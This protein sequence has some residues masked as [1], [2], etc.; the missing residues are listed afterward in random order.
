MTPMTR[1]DT[2]LVVDDSPDTIRLLTDVLDSAGMTVMVA[3]D[4]MAALKVATRLKPDIVLMDAVMPG[5]DGFETCRQLKTLSGFDDVPVIFMTGLTEPEDSVRGFEAG[6]ADYVTKPIVLDSMLAR[7]RVHLSNARK[8]RSAR[9]A[10]DAAEQFLVAVDRDGE[11]TW[12]TPQAYRLLER[13]FGDETSRR[14]RLPED[15]LAWLRARAQN[16]SRG[17]TLT[18]E[19]LCTGPGSASRIRFVGRS[20]Q[21]EI[22]FRIADASSP[23]NIATIRA[24]F[25]LTPREAEVAVWIAQGKSNRDIAAILSLSPRTVDKHLELIFTKLNV[26]NRTTAAALIFSS[27]KL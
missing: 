24:K 2:V 14:L 15:I 9:L 19:R 21:G 6:G 22:L 25:A 17:A 27:M 11:I 16:A 18:E 1:G 13:S 4:G 12:F 3:L 5:M 7:I 20:E 8:I 26:E 10:L 23:D